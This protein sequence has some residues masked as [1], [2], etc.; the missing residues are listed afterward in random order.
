MPDVTEL[1]SRQAARPPYFL[2]IDVGGTNLKFGIVDDLGRTL[3]RCSIRTEQE[4][5][6]EDACE[7]MNAVGRKLAA[8]CSVEMEDV[9][10]VGLATPGTMDVAAGML[11]QPHNLPA[12]WNFPIRAHLER[13]IGKP[14]SF[15]ND[16]N[17]AAYG[18][19][20]VGSGAEFRSMVFFTLGTGVG[21]GIV[22][23]GHSVDGEHSHGSECGHTYVDT[24][25]EAR[26][27]GC[28]QRGHLEAYVSAKAVVQRT[29]E[30]LQGNRNSAIAVRLEAGE[31]LTPLMVAQEAE[32]DDPVA[33]EIIMETAKY[34]S[35][36]VV[37]M[38]HI[39]DPNAVILGGAMNFGGHETEVGRRFL[40][41]IRQEVGMRAFP[42]L[43]EVTHINFAMLGGHAGYIGAAAIARSHYQST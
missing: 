42:A 2:A 24:S 29:R 14:V 23:D 34:L 15:A 6:P 38:M 10:R 33:L 30:A 22:L 35:F 17:A 41:R 16:A 7:R 9:A 32:Q 11:L 20:W 37:N 28:G 40:E 25:P 18:E 21:G 4:K 12:W 5:G 3:G 19:Y 31:E 26:M 39:I 8:D 13:V 43:V 36:G 1:I 27:C